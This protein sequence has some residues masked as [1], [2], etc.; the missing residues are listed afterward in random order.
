MCKNNALLPAHANE[1]P[2]PPV[3]NRRGQCNGSN[4]HKKEQNPPARYYRHPRTATIC[5]PP[6]AGTRAWFALFYL[7]FRG[8][9]PISLAFGPV[10]YCY[11]CPVGCFVMCLVAAWWR[12]A[13]TSSSARSAPST[14]V[15]F[16]LGYHARIH[17]PIPKSF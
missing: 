13:G 1:V 12:D 4:S 14:V 16:P 9:A 7:F 2:P 11:Y 6:S 17:P 5:P 15:Q 10:C 3:G 8:V